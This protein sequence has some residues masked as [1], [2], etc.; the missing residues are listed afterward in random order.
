M[1]DGARTT[2]ASGSRCSQRSASST[3]EGCA[4]SQGL[5]NQPSTHPPASHPFQQPTQAEAVTFPL[6]CPAPQAE[7]TKSHRLLAPCTRGRAEDDPLGRRM[8]TR[9]Q[10][11]LQAL[12]YYF[13]SQRTNYCFPLYPTLSAPYGTNPGYSFAYTLVPDT[14]PLLQT[15]AIDKRKIL[16]VL[17]P[18]QSCPST[19]SPSTASAVGCLHHTKSLGDTGQAEPA[20]HCNT[21]NITLGQKQAL[22]AASAATLTSANA[23]SNPTALLKHQRG[24]GWCLF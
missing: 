8:K 18:L 22:P 10:V 9:S 20:V 6:R 21:R 2:R 16:L 24:K 11:H 23:I 14:I 19:N 5:S 12:K 15:N 3:P 4:G 7:G 1:A 17:Q 13:I